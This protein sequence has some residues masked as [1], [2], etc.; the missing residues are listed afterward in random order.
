MEKFVEDTLL[1]AVL[2]WLCSPDGTER[3]LFRSLLRAMRDIF[4]STRRTAV[5]QMQRRLSL[6]ACGCVPHLAVAPYLRLIGAYCQDHPEEVPAGAWFSHTIVPLFSS[7]YLPTFYT[8]LQR[9]CLFME[10]YIDDA[11]EATVR[12]LV[13]HWPVSEPMK[14][15]FFV[16]SL[17]KSASR[18]RVDAR[19]PLG[20][21]VF[22]RIG[23]MVASE[24]ETVNQAA[25]TA[26][27]NVSFLSIFHED[28][29]ELMRIV[30]ETAHL[31]HQDTNPVTKRKVEEAIAAMIGPITTGEREP[32]PQSAGR[33][34][35]WGLV[36]DCAQST[37]L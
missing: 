17:Q 10:S 15:P 35:K 32:R 33:A 19:R 21:T 23:Q 7:V 31:E 11:A 26:L 14:V 2:S 30:C 25:L 29:R 34:E 36:A 8:E 28:I 24:H 3:Q 27:A 13:T 5:L 1:P 18:L 37:S 20:K 16:D 6:V 9:F 12:Y 4:P 22:Q